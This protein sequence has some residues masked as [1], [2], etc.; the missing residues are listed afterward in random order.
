LHPIG[1]VYLINIVV[2]KAK[3]TKNPH[4]FR[5]EGQGGEMIPQNFSPEKKEITES[6]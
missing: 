6:S 2:L 5:G 3:T 4:L 1:F